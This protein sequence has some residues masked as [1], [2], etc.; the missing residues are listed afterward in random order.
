MDT[1]VLEENYHRTPT[2]L[3]H[4]LVDLLRVATAPA[5]LAA[6]APWWLTVMLAT[7]AAAV[8]APHTGLE[9][10]LVAEGIAEAEATQTATSLMSHAASTMPVAELKKFD[11]RSPPRQAKTTASLPY[12]LDFATYISQKNSSLWGSPSTMRS[13]IQSNGSDAMPSPSKMLVAT[14]T[15]CASTSPS[16]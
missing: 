15:R 11:A 3:G 13:K 7:E 9:G 12:L 14:T 2:A 6:V 4:R 1:I 5:A 10:E 8:G 16:V